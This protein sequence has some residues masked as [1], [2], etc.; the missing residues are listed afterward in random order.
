V[1]SVK[2]REGGRLRVA[3]FSD[4]ATPHWLPGALDIGDEP[5]VLAYHPP[6]A[7]VLGYPMGLGVFDLSDPSQPRELARLPELAGSNDVAVGEDGRIYVVAGS[8]GLV[9]VVLE[10]DVQ[11]DMPLY[12]PLAQRVPR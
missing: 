4:P 10:G 8:G 3:D 12:L 1:A 11:G 2:S 7:Y 5:L 6:L 9:T